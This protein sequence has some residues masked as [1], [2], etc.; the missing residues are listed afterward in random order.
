MRVGRLSTETIFSLEKSSGAVGCFFGG[1]V[2]AMEL[3]HFGGNV[4]I[5]GMMGDRRVALLPARHLGL[6]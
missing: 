5:P 3:T 6:S 1:A 4:S 2:R